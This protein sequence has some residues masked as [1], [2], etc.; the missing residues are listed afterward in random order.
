MQY[1][2]L[3]NSS[4]IDH[5]WIE[6]A[7]LVGSCRNIVSSSDCMGGMLISFAVSIVTGDYTV[8]LTRCP[9]SGL[10]RIVNFH[11]ALFVGIHSDA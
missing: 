1:G 6:K 8:L 4:K 5:C 10:L 9:L 3:T 2:Q 11:C 7:R